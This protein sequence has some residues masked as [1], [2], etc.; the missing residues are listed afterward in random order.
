M[1]L[2]QGMLMC[3]WDLAKGCT[4]SYCVLFCNMPNPLDQAVG[5]AISEAAKAGSWLVLQ[6]VDL[7]PAWLKATLLPWVRGLY[8]LTI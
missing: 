8:A 2:G 6:T 1:G 5:K 3:P 7:A 4:Q